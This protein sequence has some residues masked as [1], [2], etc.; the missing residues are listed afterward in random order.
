MLCMEQLPVEKPETLVSS[1]QI[2]AMV[3]AISTCSDEEAVTKARNEI[4]GA[5][6]VVDQLALS[7]R[8]AGKDLAREQKKWT[9]AKAKTRSDAASKL[10]EE[11]R[12][13]VQAQE[14]VARK[15]ITQ[16]R[17][18]GCLHLDWSKLGHQDGVVKFLVGDVELAKAWEEGF[19]LLD[20]PF[21]VLKSEIIMASMASGKLATA[22][23]AFHK[24]FPFKEQ[25]LAEDRTQAP[26]LPKHGA[27]DLAGV[28]DKLVPAN[29]KVSSGLPSL[30][31]MVSAPYTFGYTPSLF[32]RDVEPDAL[33]SMRIY[34][35]G[36]LRCLLAP[37]EKLM[38]LVPKSLHDEATVQGNLAAQARLMEVMK[39]ILGD[40][41]EESAREISGTCLVHHFSF[42]ARSG[43][44]VAVIIPA[45]FL[46][47]CAPM[48]NTH[49]SGI[50]MSFLGQSKSSLTSLQ[51]ALQTGIF[52]H[53]KSIVD[54]LAVQ[55]LEKR[56]AIAA[57]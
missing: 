12:K 48:N 46:Y 35:T 30:E 57:C 32:A 29:C 5:L 52:P 42:S 53:L 22:L 37:L 55:P 14:A 50:R 18:V 4:Q 11:Q 33:G 56:A 36:D 31:A 34:Y 45:G 13:Q 1:S 27:T 40:A 8:T 20:A 16:L 44:P 26:L 3:E 2:L 17:C 54:L 38:L 25:A 15:K 47:V 28:W 21:I 51:A 9:S 7:L 39:G 24:Q 19:A 10:L 6:E 23:P 43:D 41:T 49:V